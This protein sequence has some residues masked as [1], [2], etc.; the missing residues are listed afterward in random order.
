MET[1]GHTLYDP[2]NLQTTLR[3]RQKCI[4]AD[5]KERGEKPWPTSEGTDCL[6]CGNHL[7]VHLED[8]EP[9]IHH[10][11]TRGEPLRELSPGNLHQS[12]ITVPHDTPCPMPVIG[13]YVTRFT[14]KSGRVVLA[15]DLR[16]NFPKDHFKPPFYSTFQSAQGHRNYI[17]NYAQ[18][19]VATCFMGDGGVYFMA[20]EGGL[21]VIQTLGDNERTDELQ[22]RAV[23]HVSLALW[24]VQI[25]DAADLPEGAT[26]SFDRPLGFMD[27]EPGEY[28]VVCHQELEYQPPDRS[29]DFETGMTLRKVG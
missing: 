13:P 15:N 18:H 7:G 9:V 14:C 26:D 22:E 17:D 12:V 27:R 6:H 19:G 8:G 10:Q 29:Q 25:M 3:E 11:S 16:G 28:E 2:D 21:D 24:W 23:H 20:A 4:D 1:Y 5:A